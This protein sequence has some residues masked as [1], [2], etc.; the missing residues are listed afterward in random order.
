MGEWA[1]LVICILVG[2]FAEPV[3]AAGVE[4]TGCRYTEE[5][6][7]IGSTVYMCVLVSVFLPFS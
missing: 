1:A 3:L 5:F 2:S 4:E 7:A 6:F